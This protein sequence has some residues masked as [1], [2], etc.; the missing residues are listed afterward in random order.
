M[1]REWRQDPAFVA[2][3]DALADEFALADAMIR[4]RTLA[5]MTQEQVAT[6]MGTTQAV[7]ARLESGRVKPSTR[8]LERFAQAT[9]TRLRISF[10]PVESAS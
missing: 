7:V 3:Y 9:G 1:I 4:A 8:T 5:D 6:A 2:A 10:D